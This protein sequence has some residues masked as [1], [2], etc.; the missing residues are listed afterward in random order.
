MPSK[1]LSLSCLFYEF[2][3]LLH[4]VSILNNS[5]N[6][7]ALK[8]FRQISTIGIIYVFQRM[9]D[10]HVYLFPHGSL[11]CSKFLREIR[12]RRFTLARNCE[13]RKFSDARTS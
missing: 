11:S 13:F 9:L 7:G 8:T 6:N 5:N 10:C 2:I 12:A 4:L 1:V 3:R